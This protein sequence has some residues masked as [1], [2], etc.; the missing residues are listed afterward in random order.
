MPSKPLRSWDD[1]Y[2]DSEQ[3]E[4][5]E[6][7]NYPISNYDER[8]NEMFE[9]VMLDHLSGTTTMV[10]IQMLR[11]LAM[12]Q[13][14]VAKIKLEK[15]L[16]NIY[17]K[18]GTGQWD[19]PESLKTNVDRG[20]WPIPIQNM[21]KFRLSES[22]T[23]VMKN[24]GELGQIIVCEHLQVLDE[25]LQHILATYNTK[26][27]QSI[28]VTDETEKRIKNFI[29]RYSLV[30]YQMKLN[31]ELAILLYDYDDQLLERTYLQMKPTDY[32]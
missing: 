6:E 22:K 19:T 8:L 26:K 17:L 2:V 21:I 14:E 27:A 7:D 9:K 5:E 29:T 30:S 24:E 1:D 31:Y 4:E 11:E 15:K 16:W 10:S 25:K 18:A 32:Q 13:H 23:S 3:E 20:V 28:G 12:L